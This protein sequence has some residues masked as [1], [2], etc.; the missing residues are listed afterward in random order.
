M[1]D[2]RQSRAGAGGPQD[3][4]S[5]RCDAVAASDILKETNRALHNNDEAAYRIPDER[6]LIAQEFLMLETSG[7]KALFRLLDSNYQKARVTVISPWVDALYFGDYVHG[8]LGLGYNN[9]FSNT[10]MANGT[11]GLSLKY[12]LTRVIA[13]QGILGVSSSAPKN[14]TTA[15]KLFKSV[16]METSLNFY[17]MVGGGLIS[18][19]TLSGA[20][21]L[22]GFGVEFF[23][24]GLESLGFSFETGVSFSNITGSFAVKTIG[25]SIID[26]GV[27]FYF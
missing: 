27:H 26:A 22:L 24:P 20:E 3:D 14:S 15:F 11:P 10:K 21:F 19:A 16:H 8:R 9:Q 18:A 7:A 5:S 1:R 23:I 25:A 4:R 12:G 17:F 6:A 2:L 13:I